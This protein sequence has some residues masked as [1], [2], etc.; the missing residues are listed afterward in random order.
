MFLENFDLDFSV[1]YEYHDTSVF[2]ELDFG[3]WYLS[4]NVLY[5]HEVRD[6]FAA[7]YDSPRECEIKYIPYAVAEIIVCY[8]ERDLN[9]GDA[10]EKI[11]SNYIL[12][13][14]LNKK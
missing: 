10:N 4:Y 6:Y 8:R 11:I 3:N 13:R 5:A 14:I 7:T 1:D 9:L 12:T 2:K